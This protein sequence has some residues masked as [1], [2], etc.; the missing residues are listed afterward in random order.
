M[1]IKPILGD[2]GRVPFD[3]GGNTAFL[4][5]ARRNP[6]IPR[7]EIRQAQA[8]LTALADAI[9]LADAGNAKDNV[10]AFLSGLRHA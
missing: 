4:A 6:V 2:S 7:H 1:K 8:R 9:S 3:L 5:L 10:E